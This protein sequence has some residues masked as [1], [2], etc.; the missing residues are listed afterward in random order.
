MLQRH[1]RQSGVVI[2]LALIVFIFFDDEYFQ[3]EPVM[4]GGPS[5][6]DTDDTLLVYQDNISEGDVQ[7]ISEQ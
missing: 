1:G 6:Y 4:Y 3:P 5:Y 2:I 7:D